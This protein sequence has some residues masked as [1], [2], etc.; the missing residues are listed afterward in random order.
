M[1]VVVKIKM[2]ADHIQLDDHVLGGLVQLFVRLA[3][4]S[5]FLVITRGKHNFKPCSTLTMVSSALELDLIQVEAVHARNG[6]LLDWYLQI[7]A[8]ELEILLE[9]FFLA[10]S[11]FNQCHFVVAILF[12]V[13]LLENEL[14]IRFI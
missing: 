6:F 2:A 12:I 11:T 4:Y 14:A 9:V 10:R 1:R 5:A 7:V 3:F 8:V 13:S